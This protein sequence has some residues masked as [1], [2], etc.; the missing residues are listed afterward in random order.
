MGIHARI[1]LLLMQLFCHFIK[2]TLLTDNQFSEY[3][4]WYNLNNYIISVHVKKPRHMCISYFNYHHQTEKLTS[5]KMKAIQHTVKRNVEKRPVAFC[6]FSDNYFS[7]TFYFSSFIAFIFF[8]ML[9][10][11]VLCSIFF[12]SVKSSIYSGKI[13]GC[14]K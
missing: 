6:K 12:L 4:F 2:K 14:K 7:I 8:E 5:Q 13:K 10:V 11:S 1:H 3:K 9:Q